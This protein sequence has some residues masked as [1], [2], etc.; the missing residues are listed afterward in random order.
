M[1]YPSFGVVTAL[2]AMSPECTQDNQGLDFADT[3]NIADGS[4]FIIASGSSAR[5]FPME[6]FADIPMITMNG[7]VALFAKSAIK[8]FFYICTDTSFPL[9]QPDLFAQALKRSRR[10]ALWPEQLQAL[11]IRAVGDLFALKKAQRCS[12]W[13]RLSGRDTGLVRKGFALDA[14]SRSLGFSKDLSKGFFD[15]RTVAYAALQLAYHAGFTKVFLVGVDLNQAAGRF[16]ETAEC[17]KSPCGLDQHFEGRVLPSLKLMSEKVMGPR[18]EV[19]N[20]SA[21][22]RIPA[23]VIPK[24]DIQTAES[25]IRRGKPEQVAQAPAQGSRGEPRA[26]RSSA[27]GHR[28]PPAA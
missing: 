11:P 28:L 25:I 26:E 14:R 8:P 6:R 27:S 16:Y 19:Y 20:L 2:K 4:V 3:R 23:S 15:A 13:E 12:L 9:Q 24:I 5:D 22:S 7:A 10:V 18:F 21:A 17:G 1:A